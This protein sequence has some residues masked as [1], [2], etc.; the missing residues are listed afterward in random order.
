MGC[1]ENHDQARLLR[2]KVSKLW[3]EPK[4]K[5]GFLARSRGALHHPARKYGMP[6]A[7]YSRP[8]ARRRAT[9]LGMTQF[10]TVDRKSTRLNSSHPSTSYAVFCLK[11][12]T[13]TTN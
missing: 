3:G 7:R 13:Q 6:R 11:K 8:T 2:K 5:S 4:I 9:P 1:G 10:L 12:K